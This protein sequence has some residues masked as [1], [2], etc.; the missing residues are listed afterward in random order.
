MT[1][2]THSN[3]D[4]GSRG[5]HPQRRKGVKCPEQQTR[6]NGHFSRGIATAGRVH[7]FGPDVSLVAEVGMGRMARNVRS[8]L[9][10]I[11]FSREHA[12]D[13]RFGEYFEQRL[14]AQAW[15]EPPELTLHVCV[16]DNGGTVVEVAVKRLSCSESRT[17][18]AVIEAICISSALD[19]NVFYWTPEFPDTRR[20]TC[21]NNLLREDDAPCFSWLWKPSIASFWENENTFCRRLITTPKPPPPSMPVEPPNFDLLK[22]PPPDGNAPA[23]S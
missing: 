22:S 7:A 11:E 9:R 18:C 13:E 21:D 4:G 14:A 20:A 6:K 19:C 15:T 1:K 5:Q 2:T 3:N 8:T 23:T 16:P 17:F 12:W 10:K